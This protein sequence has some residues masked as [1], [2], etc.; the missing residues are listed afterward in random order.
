MYTIYKIT[1]LRTD[2][3]IYIGKTIAFN[4]RKSMHFTQSKYPVDKYMLDEGR[5]N[6]EMTKI[7]DNV[8]T[9]EEAV[10]I[11]DQYIVEL[12]PKMNKQRS[13]NISADMKEYKNE[14]YKSEKWKEYMKEYMKEYEKSEK[15][16]E[17]RRQYQQSEKCKE[18]HRQYYLKKKQEQK[19]INES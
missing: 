19:N 4:V 1:D 6:F 7:Q 8:K 17:Y 15:C 13:G 14:Y 12:N 5:D 10:K 9:N 11:E 16:K 2:Q 18:Y 3:I